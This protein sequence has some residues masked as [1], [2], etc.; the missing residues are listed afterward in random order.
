M[1]PKPQNRKGNDQQPRNHQ[2]VRKAQ[3]AKQKSKAQSNQSRQDHITDTGIHKQA[4]DKTRIPITD[5]GGGAALAMP[6]AN[7]A[8]PRKKAADAMLKASIGL[9]KANA[10]HSK[11]A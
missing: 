3:R 11:N 1:K 2:Q 7:L 5:L 10:E 9:A 4:Q 6:E 8:S